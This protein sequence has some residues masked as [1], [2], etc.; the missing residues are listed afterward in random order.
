MNLR[1][2]YEPKH[3]HYFIGPIRIKRANSLFTESLMFD[4]F[5]D[6][7]ITDLNL[8]VNI[9]TWRYAQQPPYIL[10]GAW[11]GMSKGRAFTCLN[12]T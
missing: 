10:K 4:M 12:H 5:R 2:S 1:L 11:K 3:W 6:E 9:S 7:E 8:N